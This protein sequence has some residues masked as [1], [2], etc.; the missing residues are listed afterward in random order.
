MKFLSNSSTDPYFNMAFDEYCLQQYDS[1]EP[2]FY[3][4]RNRPSVIIGLNQNAYGEV[5][6]GYLESHGILLARRVTGGGAVY[7]DL[8]NLNYSIVGR[9]VSPEPV[10]EA[11]REFGVRA[12]LGGRNDIFVD[13]RKVSGYARRV[14]HDKELI[15]G[16]LM[17][18]VD[19]ETLTEVLNV[20]GS[21]LE[22]KGIASVHSRV[23]NLRDYLPQFSSVLE[24]EDALQSRL[25]GGDG[26][27]LL[28]DTDIAAVR[29]LAE[30]KFS[31]W[32]WIYGHSKEVSLVRKN[33]L[34]CGTVEAG[35]SLEQGLIGSVRFSGDFLG[36]LPSDGLSARL[37]GVRFD[38]ASILE[39]LVDCDVSAV[40]SGTDADALA[41]L[42][43]NQRY[44]L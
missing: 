37:R 16:T 17:F 43:T 6:L 10:A 2:V 30:E 13:G 39:A 41:D 19:L 36:D 3:L 31:R 25:A 11:L 5:N 22:A 24:F 20:S 29:K 21:K 8:Q 38:R 1:E 35:I 9:N 23:A 14:W 40:F 44:T 28:S 27:I 15:H 12:E 32:E 33:R 34:A 42:M 26:E 7:H 4:W 18:D